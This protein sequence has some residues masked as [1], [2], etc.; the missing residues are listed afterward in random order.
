MSSIEQTKAYAVAVAEASLGSFTKQAR[1]DLEA[2]N[3]DENVRLYTAKGGSAVTLASDTTSAAVVF[4]PES[5]LRN[6][7]MNV[8]VYERNASNAVAAVQTVS[9]GR[10]TNE[11]LSA[12]ILSSGLKVFNSSG[13]DVIGGTQTA[14][15]LTAVPRDISTITTTDV[16]NFCSNHERDLV[17]GVVSREDSTMTMC[18]TDHFGKKMSLSRSNTLGNVVERSWDSSIGTRLTTEGENLMKVGSR[19]MVATASGATNAEIL[20]NENRRLIDTNFLSAGNNPLTLATYNATVEARIVMNDPGSAVAQFKINVRA[21]GVDAAGTVVAEVNLT[22]ILT[23]AASSVYT[24]SAATTLTSATTPIH[25][26]ILGLVST[27]SDVTDTLRAADSSAVVKAFEETADIPARP[28]HVCVFE[29]LN[30]S[31]TLNINS[32]AVMTGVPD[33]TNVFIS[34][35]G[36]VSRVVYDTNLVEMFLRSVS[37]VLPRAHTITGHGAMEKAVMAVF[38]SEDIKLSFQAMSFGDVIKK[39]SGA[40]K[41]AKATIRDVSD[42]AKE[43]EPILSA[44]M[45]I[46]R[47]MI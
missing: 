7:Q 42:I 34:S 22:D 44:G 46:G 28:I 37:R 9:L 39:L 40:G 27:S 6:G 47:M 41:F 3:G 11:F 1:G 15:V 5:S 8:V 31:A 18:M 13:V 17:S 23:T 20:A 25:R 29:G 43:V 2:P 12:G 26:V 10:S 24:F 32:T 30:A 16:A 36:S 38:G 14:A 4:D 33:S 35:A 19:T 21:L 45:A